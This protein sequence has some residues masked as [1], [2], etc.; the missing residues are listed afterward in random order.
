MT[1]TTKAQR[2]AMRRLYQRFAQGDSFDGSS[3]R[4]FRKR[5]VA[6]YDCMMIQL[7]GMWLG[8]ERD[9]YCHS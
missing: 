1:P 9:G 6:G 2:L 7:W 5:F 8:I 3:Y 4:Q